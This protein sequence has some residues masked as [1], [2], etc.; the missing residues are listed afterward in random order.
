MECQADFDDLLDVCIEVAAERLSENWGFD[1]VA[2]VN[3]G[4]GER[5][6]VAT[7]PQDTDEY[8]LSETPIRD[9]LVGDLRTRA[10][11]MRSYAIVSNVTTEDDG[12]E[13]LEVLLEHREYAM[14]ILVPYEMP[15]PSTFNLGPMTAAVSPHLVWD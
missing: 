5:R 14:Q 6:I 13:Q 8:A 15:D 2:V 1:P 11:D 4:D 10:D 9:R 3:S 12:A 7:V